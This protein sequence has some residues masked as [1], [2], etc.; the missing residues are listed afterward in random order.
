M[1]DN[2]DNRT[3]L[4]NDD[5]VKPEEIE[6]YYI[7]NESSGSASANYLSHNLIKENGIIVTSEK[8]NTSADLH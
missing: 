1:K 8:H 4:N 5:I 3:K 2:T 7:I 6:T